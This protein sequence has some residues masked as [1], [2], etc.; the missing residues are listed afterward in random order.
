M[1]A[2]MKEKK[3]KDI[4]KMDMWKVKKMLKRTDNEAKARKV[5]RQT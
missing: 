5:D 1:K 3:V 2:E 4:E